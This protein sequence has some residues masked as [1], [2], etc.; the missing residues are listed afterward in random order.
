MRAQVSDW[1]VIE[2]AKLDGPRRAGQVVELRHPDG[3]PP[4]LV[5]WMD[6]GETT[7][8]FPGPDAR[9]LD[10]QGYQELAERKAQGPSGLH[11]G[12]R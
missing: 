3:S 2:S 6:T 11:G 9:V 5:H 7:L 8:T 12:V 4:Y 10:E 1:I